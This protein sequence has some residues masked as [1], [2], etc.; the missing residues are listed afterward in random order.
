MWVPHPLQAGPS[1]GGEA[2]LLSLTFPRPGAKAGGVAGLQGG[3]PSWAQLGLHSPK[4]LLCSVPPTPADVVAAAPAWVPWA[5]PGHPP[6][7]LLI[8][9]GGPGAA[10]GSL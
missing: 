10:A 4:P 9:G 6:V 2:C 3:P 7:P 8:T 1:G 5:G